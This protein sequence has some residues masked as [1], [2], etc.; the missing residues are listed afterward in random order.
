MP[1]MDGFEVARRIRAVRTSRRPAIIAL[2]GW[3]QDGDRQRARDAG[4]DHHLVKPADI[5]AIQALLAA[6]D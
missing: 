2:T 3:G 6:L 1:G 4:F 5:A